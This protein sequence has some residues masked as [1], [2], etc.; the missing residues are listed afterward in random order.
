M[1]LYIL[2]NNSKMNRLGISISK[3]YGKSVKRNR[4]KRLIKENY[5]QYEEYIKDGYDIVI[6][7]RNN[8]DLPDFAAVR[9]EMK[10]LMKKLRIFDQEKWDCSKNC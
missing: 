4:L 1:V 2:P 5:R 3:K 10:Y 7:A 9:K 6:T 8:T